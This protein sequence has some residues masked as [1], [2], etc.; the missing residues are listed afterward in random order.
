MAFTAILDA[1]VLYPMMLRDFLITLATTGLYRAKRTEQIND[2]WVRNLLN[3]RHVLAAAI[4]CGAQII[5]THNL[6]VLSP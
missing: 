6:K 4:R 3:D 1:N 2:E 5:V